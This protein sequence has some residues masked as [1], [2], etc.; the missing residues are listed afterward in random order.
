MIDQRRNMLSLVA[1]TILLVHLQPVFAQSDGSEFRANDVKAAIEYT[2]ALDVCSD[3]KLLELSGIDS[4][5]CEARLAEFS[6]VCWHQLDRLKLNYELAKD[7]T[8]REQFIG[9]S[10]V[11]E[12]CIRAE[13]LRKIVR[14]WQD[15]DPDKN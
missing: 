4:S 5:S 13:L 1:S 14:A 15:S 7:D 8:G 9:I 6:A 2:V 12:S 10:L 11:Y 3:V